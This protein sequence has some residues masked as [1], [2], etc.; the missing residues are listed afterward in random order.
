MNTKFILDDIDTSKTRGK[1]GMDM[2]KKLN[3]WNTDKDSTDL[4]YYEVDPSITESQKALKNYIKENF[5][6]LQSFPLQYH[7]IEL[8]NADTDFV[9][10]KFTKVIDAKIEEAKSLSAIYNGIL[11]RK[12]IFEKAFMKLVK[13]LDAVLPDPDNDFPDDYYWDYGI[14]VKDDIDVLKQEAGLF[15]GLYTGYMK[16]IIANCVILSKMLY[17]K[18]DKSDD[19]LQ[20]DAA[21]LK[22]TNDNMMEDLKNQMKEESIKK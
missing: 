13:L 6:N 2:D 14:Y 10:N 1:I 22:I 3:Q 19:Q 8:N 18:E 7:K 20:K 5:N 4:V 12:A 9:V 16:E 11:K 21:D 15:C 17:T